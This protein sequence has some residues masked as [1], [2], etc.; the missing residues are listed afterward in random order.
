MTELERDKAQRTHEAKAATTTYRSTP[1]EPGKTAAMVRAI[2]DG[3]VSPRC[4]ST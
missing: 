2:S 3:I 1:S 4:S